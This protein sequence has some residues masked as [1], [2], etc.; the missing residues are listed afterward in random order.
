MSPCA[1]PVPFLQ[2]PALSLIFPPRPL[3]AFTFLTS[4]KGPE[5]EKGLLCPGVGEGLEK[6]VNF[7]LGLVRSGCVHR[8][9]AA[10]W[11]E[12]GDRQ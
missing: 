9:G 1:L 7:E 12:E 3:K 10:E 5:G 4:R 11:G 6:D 8:E 2:Y